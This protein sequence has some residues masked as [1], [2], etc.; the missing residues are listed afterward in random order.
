MEILPIQIQAEAGR[1][2]INADP[3][4]FLT[5]PL[6]KIEIPVIDHA[7]QFGIDALVFDDDVTG[8]GEGV[9]CAGGRPL[10]NLPSPALRQ[11]T[12]INFSLKR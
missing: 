9:Y 1:G 8:S 11:N 5:R 7:L 2:T 6:C 12:S 3:T 4:C 10:L